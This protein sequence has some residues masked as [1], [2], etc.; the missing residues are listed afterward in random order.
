[1]SDLSP[2]GAAAIAAA[3]RG[4]FVFPLRHKS[5]EPF[6][7]SAGFK[8]A[9]NDVDVV[10]RLWASNPGAN[11]GLVPGPS[12]LL[13]LDLDGAAGLENG[14]RLGLLEIATLTVVTGRGDGG[15][16]LY[17][18]HPGGTIGNRPLCDK[19]D[20]RA[21]AGYVVLPP[22]IHPQSD[23]PYSF[24]DSNAQVADLPSNIVDSLRSHTNPLAVALLTTSDNPT[25]GLIA[26]GQRNSTLASIAGYLRY[27]GIEQ[28]GIEAALCALNEHCCD[29]PLRDREVAA[30][31]KS[32]SR[33]P[34]GTTHQHA[35]FDDVA[36]LME[37]WN[38]RFAVVQIGGKA[39]VAED[40]DGGFLFYTFANFQQ[41]YQPVA[42]WVVE[43]N[44]PSLKT[45]ADTWL[46][47]PTRTQYKGIVFAP[48]ETQRPGFL[49]MWRG[50]AVEPVEGDC[51]LFLAHIR[52]NVCADNPDHF[53]WFISWLADIVQ[54]PEEKSGA[55]VVLRGKQGV[56]KT[57]VGRSIGQLLGRH[58]QLVSDA[59]HI[60]GH[61][62]RHLEVCL[63]LQAEEAFW[64]GDKAAEGTLKHL[65]TS[66]RILIERKGV[67]SYEA[68]NFTRILV[69]SNAD[70]VVPA[71]LEERRF[72]VLDVGEAHRRDFAY[73][74]AIDHELKNGGHEALLYFLFQWRY[75]SAILRQPLRTLAL[76][77]QKLQ[78]LNAEQGWLLDLL[79]RGALPGDLNGNGECP[80]ELLRGDYLKHAKD[81]GRSHRSIE[82]ML[83]IFLRNAIPAISKC[84]G[85]YVVRDEERSGQILRFPPL[86]E[87]R[88][89]F[90]EYL[91][92]DTV[93]S[94]EPN[95]GWLAATADDGF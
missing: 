77:H 25:D 84:R 6:R 51:S 18:K 36:S 90:R 45:A 19:I 57:I 12:G 83:G 23:R 72:T 32:I 31:A 75:D 64:A 5:K 82:T 3:K 28:D 80:A 9:T 53:K 62:N 94:D 66:D 93:L 54:R 15:L 43:R 76:D 35:V 38:T 88:R 86:A 37:A 87:S 39:F 4:W 10:Q 95:A 91:N 11:I 2:L 60:T 74:A 68:P 89:M 46:K 81:S 49:N 50:F 71:G 85:K 33:Y 22:S 92:M 65:I 70:W 56:G 1:V 61:F 42:V 24:V 55:S 20:V 27:R 59:R 41:L 67:D 40:V 16:H 14:R 78:S 79:E 13:I 47:C 8:A 29:P 26:A 63:L 30:I 52:H 21:D 48:G 73:F 34:T 17:F 44:K 58:Y 7:G 69:T